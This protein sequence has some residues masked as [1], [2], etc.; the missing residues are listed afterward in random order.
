MT[1]MERRLAQWLHAA[2]PPA[3][4]DLAERILRQTAATRQRRR[5]FAAF[6]PPVVFSTATVV[7]LAVV[8]GL[9]LGQ[10]FANGPMIGGD[11][12]RP[13]TSAGA[14]PSETA[15][16]S[17]SPGPSDEPVPNGQVCRND[18]V[19]YALTFPADWFA[20]PEVPA[21]A[22]LTPVAACRF[23]A[24]VPFEVAPNAGVPPE[25]AI[26][27]GRVQQAPVAGEV[28]SSRT[29]TVAGRRATVRLVL[30]TAGGFLP[31]GTRVYEYLLPLADGSLLQASTAST[32]EGTLEEHAMVLDAMMRGLRLEG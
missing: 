15:V 26:S 14:A 19:G 5:W 2:A 3:A 28:L 10:L 8:V 11:P 21:E 13:P 16:P 31:E 9:Q 23:F 6:S 17:G 30:A 20:N 18:E 7:V 22:P 4:P 25:V 12:S 24:P 32:D 29:E 1:D 27:I